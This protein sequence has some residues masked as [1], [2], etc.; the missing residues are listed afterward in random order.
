MSAQRVVLVVDEAQHVLPQGAAL[1]EQVHAQTGV[2]RMQVTQKPFDDKRVRQAVVSC[3]DH[4]A[5]LK[6]AYRGKGAIGENHHVSPI[7]PEY[8]KLPPLKRDIERAK[9]LL[10][11]AGHGGGLTVKVD[12][13]GDAA[14]H[15]AAMQTAKQQLAPAGI[16]LKLN[17][18]PG[19]TY[20]DVWDKT[21]FGF[22]SWTHRPLGVMVLNLGYRSGV[23]WNESKYANPAFD[24]ALDEASAILDPNERAK[25]MVKVEKIL[26]DDAVIA[27]PLWRSIFTATTKQ[28]RG[29]EIH[30]TQYHQFHKVWMA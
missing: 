8:A 6:I 5:I 2:A 18:M 19:A 1:V 20:W 21:P 27:Q 28:V 17:P 26:Q 29:Y 25:A 22:T 4:A 12:Y 10:A 30:P 14:W 3:L 13:G 24:T 9:A 15:A 11:D 7:H 23:P 16:N